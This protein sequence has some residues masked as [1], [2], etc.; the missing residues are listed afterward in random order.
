[1]RRELV[2]T[3]H[4]L[5]AAEQDYLRMGWDV[6]DRTPGQVTVERGRRGAWGWHLLFLILVPLVGNQCYSAYRRYNRP[7]QM[8][9]RIRGFADANT[10]VDDDTDQN[11]KPA[12]HRRKMLVL[13]K[14]WTQQ[15]RRS[16]P[17]V[18]INGSSQRVRSIRLILSLTTRLSL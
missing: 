18:G 8:V 1:M 12:M 3:K 11:T 13:T 6:I 9:V 5:A 17:T 7:E 15:M 2:D 10:G 4:A 16:L 14:M